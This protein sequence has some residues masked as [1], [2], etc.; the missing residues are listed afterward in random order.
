MTGLIAMEDR[1]E[2]LSPP[3]NGK[4]LNTKAE[5]VMKGVVK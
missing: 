3:H 5:Y 4:L 2:C 1:G